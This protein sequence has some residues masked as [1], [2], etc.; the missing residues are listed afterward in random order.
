MKF[1][2]KEALFAT[3][4]IAGP[5]NPDVVSAQTRAPEVERSVIPPVCREEGREQIGG[6]SLNGFHIV[7]RVLE[8]AGPNREEAFDN[9]LVSFIGTCDL[10]DVESAQNIV[11]DLSDSSLRSSLLEILE[12]LHDLKESIEWPNQEGSPV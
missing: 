11:R 10:A 8:A 12:S 2:I 9:F 7:D 4:L 6:K 5:V 1:G 3:A